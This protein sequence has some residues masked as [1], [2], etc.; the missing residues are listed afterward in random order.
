MISQFGMGKSINGKRVVQILVVWHFW[1][2][3][4]ED[5]MGINLLG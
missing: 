4:N 3:L 2:N 5:L 1:V